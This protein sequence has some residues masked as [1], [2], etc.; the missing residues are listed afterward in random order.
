M[1]S[2]KLPYS[3]KMFSCEIVP[4]NGAVAGSGYVIKTGVCYFFVLKQKILK[5]VFVLIRQCNRKKLVTRER[6]GTTDG[7]MSLVGKRESV[8]L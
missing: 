5:R 3:F 1:V 2:Q 6:Q 7:V 8:H 4:R